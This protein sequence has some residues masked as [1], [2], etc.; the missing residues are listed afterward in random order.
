MSIAGL[1]FLLLLANLNGSSALTYVSF[2]LYGVFQI[3]LYLSSTFMHQ[4][5][6][7]PTMHKPLHIMDQSAIYLL[8]AGT[9]TPV[10]LLGLGGIWGW[11]MFG[12]IWG[13]AAAG[14]VMKSFIFTGRHIASDLLYLP[15][16][17]LILVAIK[18][19]IE[20]MPRGFFLWVMIGAAAYSIGIIFYIFRKIPM[21]H[22]IW[23]MFVITGS[24]SFYIG[25]AK[26]LV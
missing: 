24:L 7:I 19:L 2:S 3:I 26:Y 10:V 14:I 15:M 25:V 21:S 22:V 4:F 20:A 5:T 17:W 6:D 1:V 11:T 9:Y 18:P 12:I 13:L 23:H 16:G 8:I